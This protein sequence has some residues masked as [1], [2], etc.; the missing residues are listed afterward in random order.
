MPST[1]KLSQN[2]PI[3]YWKFC[4]HLFMFVTLRWAYVYLSLYSRIK[5]EH[6]LGT[7]MKILCDIFIASSLIK[8]KIYGW[9][10]VS[11][12]IST[13]VGYLMPI[14]VCVCVCVYIYIYIYIYKICII[15]K[16]IVCR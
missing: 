14:S 12:G 1:N 2:I 15:C 6:I 10:I 3:K 9:L 11:S 13:L 4:T 7:H 5:Y 16:K 8:V